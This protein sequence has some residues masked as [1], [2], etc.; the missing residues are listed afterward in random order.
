MFN[1]KS[2]FDS[3]LETIKPGGLSSDMHTKLFKDMKDEKS[4]TALCCDLIK[5]LMQY[6]GTT[7]L[8]CLFCLG[9]LYQQYLYEVN[10]L[11]GL[12]SME[13]KLK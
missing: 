5:S 4:L 6:E 7:L 2:K 3:F 9:M 1:K 13:D 12:V 11:E 8:K 10:Q